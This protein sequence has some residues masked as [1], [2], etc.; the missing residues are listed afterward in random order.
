MS[1]RFKIPVDPDTYVENFSN[2]QKWPKPRNKG[3]PEPSEAGNTATVKMITPN[4]VKKLPELFQ[5]ALKDKPTSEYIMCRI[6]VIGDG[7]CLI[8]AYLTASSENYRNLTDQNKRIIAQAIRAHLWDVV[9]LLPLA[10]QKQQIRQGTL[11]NNM[12]ECGT[13]DECRETYKRFLTETSEYMSVSSEGFL[14]SKMF[15]EDLGVISTQTDKDQNDVVVPDCAYLRSKL[16]KNHKFSVLLLHVGNNH[17]EPIVIKHP[18][19]NDYEFYY[20]K[21]KDAPF[22]KFLDLVQKCEQVEIN[23]SDSAWNL[24]K[25]SGS[26]DKGKKQKHGKGEHKSSDSETDEDEEEEHEELKDSFRGSI[27]KDPKQGRPQ[28]L[29]WPE[30]YKQLAKVVQNT[31]HSVGIVF[32]QVP[33]K[34]L[35]IIS[36]TNSKTAGQTSQQIDTA[37]F[38]AGKQRGGTDEYGHYLKEV[39]RILRDQIPRKHMCDVFVDGKYS[40]IPD[41]EFLNESTAQ[42]ALEKDDTSLMLAMQS[43]GKRFQCV[44][45]LTYKTAEHNIEHYYERDKAG[46]VLEYADRAPDTTGKHVC[47]KQ[48]NTWVESKQMLE[49]SLICSSR[50]GS[51]RARKNTPRLLLMFAIAKQF[52]RAMRGEQKYLGVQLE[53]ISSRDEKSN[54]VF[55][56]KKMAEAFGF[57]Q[58][59]VVFPECPVALIKNRLDLKFGPQGTSKMYV[60]TDDIKPPVTRKALPNVRLTM[61]EKL[62]TELGNIRNVGAVGRLCPPQVRTKVPTCW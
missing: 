25:S 30:N 12:R 10:L 9:E 8:H 14:I 62:V 27:P 34:A 37:M 26:K 47:G 7:N 39:N 56:I 52:V 15:N 36:E 18:P 57:V 50:E 5:T 48:L 16:A 13:F 49:I 58:R 35:R 55:P 21:N 54:A 19:K 29:Q 44:A 1:S 2:E 40:G 24:Q 46:C 20:D 53:A 31:A 6:G 61:F 60:L 33:N 59:S 28:L 11:D 17:F 32:V 51:S 22:Q 42:T 3:F 23:T 4:T 41:I 45:F 38:E 43:D